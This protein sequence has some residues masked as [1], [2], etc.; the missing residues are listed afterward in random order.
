MKLGSRH[1]R[2]D[3]RTQ[4][5]AVQAGDA[6]N[7]QPKIDVHDGA[8][9]CVLSYST[10]RPQSR[11]DVGTSMASALTEPIAANLYPGE[12]DHFGR[13]KGSHASVRQETAC[14]AGFGSPLCRLGVTNRRTRCEHFWSALALERWGNRPAACG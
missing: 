14:T 6:K 1:L 10:P 9:S 5:D 4:T 12:L 11:T 2:A 3:G 7:R 8:L 13:P